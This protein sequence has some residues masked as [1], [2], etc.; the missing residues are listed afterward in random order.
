MSKKIT[1]KSLVNLIEKIVQKEIDKN[2]NESVEKRV[3]K[4]LPM[5]VEHEVNRLLKEEL[6]NIQSEKNYQESVESTGNSIVDEVMED[7]GNVNNKRDLREHFKKLVTG[8]RGASSNEVG[9]TINATSNDVHSIAA[10]SNKFNE[11]N[12]N[13]NV[14]NRNMTTPDGSPVDTSNPNVQKV[15][16][17]M[18]QDFSKTLKSM[19]HNSKQRNGQPAGGQ[20]P[21]GGH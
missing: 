6:K 17:I 14:V 5:L 13:P 20:I 10:G 4:L 12:G 3:Q 16:D 9:R 8:G 7:E 19:E 15:M 21:T 1:K 2:I 11:M 18:N